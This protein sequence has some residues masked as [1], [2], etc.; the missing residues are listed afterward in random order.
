MFTT[1]TGTPFSPRNF[2]RDFQE[3]AEL[4]GLP[5]IRFHD[6]WHTAISFMMSNGIP[7][8]VVQAIVGHSSPILT[9]GVYTHINTDDQT[10]AAEKISGLF[11]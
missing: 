5:R 6:L 10:E 4:A 2:F 11:A 8:A 3:Q 1:S 9:L 7:P